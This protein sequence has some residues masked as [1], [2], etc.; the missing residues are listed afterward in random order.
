MGHTTANPAPDF[1]LAAGDRL[2]SYGSAEQL[3]RVAALL[4]GDGPEPLG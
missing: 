1:V 4:R 3:R 2:L